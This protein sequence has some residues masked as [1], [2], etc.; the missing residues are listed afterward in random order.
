LTLPPRALACGGMLRLAATLA[1][2]SAIGVQWIAFQS[3]AWALMIVKYS[4]HAP[5]HQAIAETFDGAHPCSLCR[6]LDKGR[7]SERKSDTHATATQIDLICLVRTVEVLRRWDLFSYHSSSVSL[8]ERIHAPP[9]PP[10]R[11]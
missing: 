7:N 3:M 8:L 6:V 5:L 2:I 10:P 11:F 1:L 9:V 4:K